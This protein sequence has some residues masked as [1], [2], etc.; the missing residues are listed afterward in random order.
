[1]I[2]I[3]QVGAEP[4]YGRS[5]ARANGVGERTRFHMRKI[6]LIAAMALVSVAAHAG[7]TRGLSI[8]AAP[9]DIPAAPRTKQLQAQNDAPVADP[10]KPA[11]GSRYAA[12]PG[13]VDN[14]PSADASEHPDRRYDDRGYYDNAGYHPFPRRYSDAGQPHGNAVRPPRHHH[15][16][17]SADRIIAELHRYGIYW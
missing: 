14:T 11:D 6:I 16:E 1:V 4:V 12:R 7:E 3:T 8:A 13:L 15:A 9:S 10:A 2:F 17:W 5:M